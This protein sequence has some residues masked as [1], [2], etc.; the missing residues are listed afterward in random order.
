[1]YECIVTQNIEVTA[2]SHLHNN[3][4]LQFSMLFEP[5]KI[6]QIGNIR[7]NDF[8]ASFTLFNLSIT[9]TMPVKDFKQIFNISY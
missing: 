3:A 2:I 7:L 6:Y 8:T 1:M 9:V 4:S 5:N